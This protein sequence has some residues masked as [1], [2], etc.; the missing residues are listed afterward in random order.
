MFA[1]YSLRLAARNVAM[2]FSLQRRTVPGPNWVGFGARTFP[3][4]IQA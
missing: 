2:S 4:L 3:R 1:R